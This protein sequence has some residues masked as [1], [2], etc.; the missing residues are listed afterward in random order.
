[1]KKYISPDITVVEVAT[2]QNISIINTS[3]VGVSDDPR[4][5]FSSQR[6]GSGWDDYENK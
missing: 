6:R 2:D 3:N 5:D 4:D 1:M